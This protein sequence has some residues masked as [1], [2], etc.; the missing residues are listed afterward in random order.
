M[1]KSLIGDV[2]FQTQLLAFDRDIAASARARG[3]PCGGARHCG[4]YQR[5]PRGL[6]RSLGPEHSRRVS[7][8]CAER[9]CRKR[10]T[11]ASF[12]FLGRKVYVATLVIL[13]TALQLGP[14]AARLRRLAAETGVDRGTLARWR[15]W[16]TRTLQESRFW[17][18]ARAAFMP[19]ADPAL[20][21]L[22]L[23]DRFDGSPEARL[24]S[25][26]QFLLPI[27]GGA[28]GPDSGQPA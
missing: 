17:R 12:R 4:D 1:Y 25:L 10:H 2:L 7:L 27:T 6:C 16:W 28:A 20:V 24:L 23:L 11:P 15:R 14:T 19:P 22:S 26:L 18:E 8:A 5:K 9:D 3:C 13:L 21:P